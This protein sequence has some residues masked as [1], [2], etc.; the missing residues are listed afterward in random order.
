MTA[1]R[2][3]G[4][5]LCAAGLA[6]SAAA[7][8]AQTVT[9]QQAVEMS[10]SADPRIREREQVVE[11]ARAVLEEA[12]GYNGLR[13]NM[14]AF[15][16]LAPAVEGGFYENGARSG[17]TPRTD[18]GGLHGLSDWTMLQFAVVKPLYTFGKVERYSEAAQGNI[19]V[20]RGDVRLA[21][22]ETILAVNRAYYAYLAARDTRLL[23]EDVQGKLADAIKLVEK[24]LDDESGEAKQSDLYAMQAG[25]GLLGKYLG[26]ARAVEKISL[27]TLKAL[28]GTGT[29]AIL[30]VADNSIAPVPLPETA[31]KDYQAQAVGGRPEMA[32]LEA[33]FRAR[34][35]LVE[36]KQAELYPDIYAGVVGTVAYASRR[37]QMENPYIYD[38]FNTAGVTPVL[39][40]RWDVRL[41]VVPAQVAQAQA[42]LE[43]LNFK[44]KSAMI[45]I[46]L[47][48]S[49]AYTQMQALHRGQQ[50]LEA[51]AAAA[52]RWMVASYADFSAG[53]EKAD[54]VAEALKTYALTQAEYLRTVYD[55]NVAVAQMVRVTGGYK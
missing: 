7:V 21:R 36:A 52:R 40:M 38:P 45:G 41:D 35:A 8:H 51:G 4:R 33:G 11:H 39:G 15:I 17:T 55:Y 9:L 18:G 27:D 42:E 6:L 37:D 44:H 3:A 5:L 14:N 28:T 30:E 24:W 49:E 20:K 2:R 10:L 31:L 16:G 34:R 26:Q 48:V 32:Q 19:D 46:P 25:R 43:A 13:V 29:E 54:K 12:Q 1:A 53:L 50:E 23:L 47:E 22:A